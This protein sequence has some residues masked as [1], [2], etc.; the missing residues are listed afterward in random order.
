VTDRT[1]GTPVPPFEAG[2]ARTRNTPGHTSYHLP[3]TDVSKVLAARYTTSA[4]LT[5]TRA[6]LWD[7]EARKAPTPAPTSRT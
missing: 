7:M 2:F 6:M 3:D 1:A 5:L 4:P